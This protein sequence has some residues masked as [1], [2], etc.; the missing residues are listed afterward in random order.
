MIEHLIINY[1][2]SDATLDTLLGVTG[3]DTKI[4][5]AQMPHGTNIPFITHE[6]SKDGSSEENMRELSMTFDCIDD[7]YIIAGTIRDRVTKLL[8]RQDDIQG[9]IVDANYFVYWAKKVGGNDSKDSDL[10]LF[11]KKIVFDFKYMP[12]A[13]P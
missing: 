7:D 9:L 10:D 1:L 6:V 5:P 2:K 4:Y 11:S 8:D 3:T 12:K 13:L